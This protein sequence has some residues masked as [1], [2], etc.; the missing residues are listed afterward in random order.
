MGKLSKLAYCHQRVLKS[1][2]EVGKRVRETGVK[3]KAKSRVRDAMLL[4]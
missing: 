1:R 2:R 4:S 3:K